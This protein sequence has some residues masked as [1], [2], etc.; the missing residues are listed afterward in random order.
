MMGEWAPKAEAS[1]AKA[2]AGQKKYYYVFFTATRDDVRGKGLCSEG[3]KKM[4]E[5]AAR[6]ELPLWLEATTKRSHQYMP[7][8]DL[9]LSTRLFLGKERRMKMELLAKVAQESQHT[10]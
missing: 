7:S 4:Q 6:D 8:W 5:A 2:L 3:I 1:K 10:A 9:R